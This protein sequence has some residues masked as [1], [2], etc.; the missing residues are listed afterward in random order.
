[1]LQQ[2]AFDLAAPETPHPRRYGARANA[3]AEAGDSAEF[4][5]RPRESVPTSPGI[6][7]AL[8]GAAASAGWRRIAGF[9]LRGRSPYTNKCPHGQRIECRSENHF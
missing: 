1:M 7:R 9:R 8:A 5:S 4:R 6:L 2:K 3:I